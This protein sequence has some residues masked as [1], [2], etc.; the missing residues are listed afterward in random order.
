MKRFQIFFIAIISLLESQQGSAHSIEIQ[1]DVKKSLIQIT[2]KL[3]NYEMNL[4][5][6]EKELKLLKNKER[7]V[8][9]LIA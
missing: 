5:G 8:F 3:Q 9:A 7:E 4:S 6:V 1:E 2:Q